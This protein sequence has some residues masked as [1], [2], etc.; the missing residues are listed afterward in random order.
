MSGGQWTVKW[1]NPVSTSPF[2]N[3]FAPLPLLKQGRNLMGNYKSVMGK[4]L[5]ETLFCSGL[6]VERQLRKEQVFQGQHA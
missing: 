5:S 2:T 6:R 1:A 4:N 3:L